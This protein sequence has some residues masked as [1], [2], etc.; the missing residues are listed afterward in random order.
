MADRLLWI[1]R[2]LDKEKKKKNGEAGT[3][4]TT[5]IDTGPLLQ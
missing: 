5:K 3:K 4:A 2:D 1:E